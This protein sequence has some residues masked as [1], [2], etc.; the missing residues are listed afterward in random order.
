MTAR[1]LVGRGVRIPQSSV[2]KNAVPVKFAQ[3]IAEHSEQH[4]VRQLPSGLEQQSA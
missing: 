3:V 1:A 4:T 2:Y